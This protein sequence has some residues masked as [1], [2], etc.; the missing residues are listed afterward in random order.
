MRPLWF[1]VTRTFSEI[2]KS[3]KLK[4]KFHSLSVPLT[5]ITCRSS[6]TTLPKWLVL[7]FLDEEYHTASWLATAYFVF[8]SFSLLDFRS[9]FCFRF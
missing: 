4:L 8:R 3:L 6:T 1:K 5:F 2:V 9:G 7:L